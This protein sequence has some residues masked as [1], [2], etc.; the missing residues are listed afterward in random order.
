MYFKQ[1]T[2]QYFNENKEE[3]KSV[4]YIAKLLDK[5]DGAFWEAAK[6]KKAKQTGVTMAELT[7]E[8]DR[9]KR[10]GTEAGTMLH[11]EREH[12][13]ITDEFNHLNIV[14]K[15]KMCEVIDGMKWSL[16][17]E[18]LDNNTVYPELMIFDHEFKICGQADKVFV[19][20]NT[21]HLEDYK[22]D[23]TI[24]KRAYSSEFVVAERLK[25]PVQHLENCNFNVYAIKMS[26]Y[27]YM[28]WKRNK[29]LRIGDIVLE[30]LEILRDKE[31]IPILNEEGRPTVINTTKIKVPYL[32]KEVRDI[33]EYY[34]LNKL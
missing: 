27:M 22:T 29:H 21:I 24:Q 14:H 5:K 18:N 17:I 19:T 2:H 26:M 20:N 7:K 1:D 3:Y 34:K 30:H 9:K 31:T 28:L 10:L 12:R 11:D 16:P 32:R 25:E 8:W 4:S 23:K 33:F 13:L 6:K 15:K